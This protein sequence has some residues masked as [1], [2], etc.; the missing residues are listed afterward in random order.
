MSHWKQY[1]C[2]W[3]SLELKDVKIKVFYNEL[4]NSKIRFLIY[5]L[6]DNMNIE[7]IVPKHNLTVEFVS[8]NN[9]ILFIPIQSDIKKTMYI[10]INCRIT[11]RS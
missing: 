1:G 5:R 3:I 6:V 11:Y 10:K 2:V 9:P 4:E 7:S 8:T